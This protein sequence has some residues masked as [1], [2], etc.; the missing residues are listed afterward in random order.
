MAK[1]VG[2]IIIF[3]LVGA[4]VYTMYIRETRPLTVYETRE[5]HAGSQLLTVLVADTAEKRTR[6]LMNVTTLADDSGM[7]F[8]FPDLMLRTFW[9]KNT[10]I[11]LDVIWVRDGRVAGVSRLPAITKSGTVMT[12]SSPEPANTVIEVNAGWAE[13]NGIGVGS[14]IRE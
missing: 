14:E 13:R 1:T 4:V 10:Y 6:G 12:V 7:F 8:M 9:N 3:L 11:D 5:I 2:I